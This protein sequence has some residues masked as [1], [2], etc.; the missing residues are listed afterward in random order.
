M[1]IFKNNPPIVTNGLV[2]YL[3]AANKISYPGSGT[4]WQDLSGNGFSGTLVNGPT[5]S[6]DGGGSIVLDGSNDYITINNSVTSQILS[7]SVATFTM[8]LRANDTFS[9]GN[10]CSIISRGNYNTSGGYFIHLIKSS[11][12]CYVGASF[13]YSTTNSYSFNSTTGVTIDWGIWNQITVSVGDTIILY[14]NGVQKSSA[15]R[16]V[17]SII[18]GNGT[19]NTNGDTNIVLCSSLSYFPTLDQGS[20]GIWRPYNGNTSTFTLYNRVLS[21]SEIQ[22]NYNAT[23]TR[24]GLT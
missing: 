17:S 12:N 15:T 22:Q 8:W 21:A 16:F 2:L 19:I 13:S 6:T 23:K 14:V 24:F 20:G 10:Q 11:G 4:T 9:N 18:Y 5:F 7:P 3:D 1:A